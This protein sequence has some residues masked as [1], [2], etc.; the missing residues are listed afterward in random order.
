MKA[1]QVKHEKFN[2]KSLGGAQL[3]LM[4]NSRQ[5]WDSKKFVKLRD[6][7]YACN[8]LANFPFPV[9]AMNGNHVNLLN[10]TRKNSWNHFMWNYFRRILAIW[11]HCVAVGSLARSLAGRLYC[12]CVWQF[13]NRN[14]FLDQWRVW[15]ECLIIVQPS[16]TNSRW[17]RDNDT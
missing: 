14:T 4:S 3:G 10:F 6:H 12:S 9:I 5:K 11:N 15:S 17:Q 2:C 8:S 13:E 7:T 16:L 1:I